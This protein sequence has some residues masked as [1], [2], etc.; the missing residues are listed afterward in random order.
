METEDDRINLDR[1]VF[2]ELKERINKNACRRP[3]SS[4][5]ANFSDD[6]MV[7]NKNSELVEPP[8]NTRKSSFIM[9]ISGVLVLT[10]FWGYGPLTPV[11]PILLPVS[12]FI[13]AFG[14]ALIM[15]GVMDIFGFTRTYGYK[16]K[17]HYD[18]T[19]TRVFKFEESEEEYLVKAPPETTVKHSLRDSWPCKKY[20]RDSLWRAFDQDGMDVTDISLSSIDG[21][22]F[23]RIEE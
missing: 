5:T 21:T 20:D 22:I 12:A 1:N 3:P 11:I 9:L 17:A 6:I 2:D 7:S 16:W 14:I 19:I 13:A 10:S 4:Q 23:I 15:I 8:S 18:G